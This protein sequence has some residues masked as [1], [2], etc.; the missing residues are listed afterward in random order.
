MAI[1]LKY[2]NIYYCNL[3]QTINSCTE[4]F[5]F[6]SIK[7]IQDYLMRCCL[8]IV[9]LAFNR[10]S[11]QSTGSPGWQRNFGARFEA[12]IPQSSLTLG[13]RPGCNTA[14]VKLTPNA[15]V[16]LEE[17]LRVNLLCCLDLRGYSQEPGLLR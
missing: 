9:P 1:P 11:V 3:I 10:Q 8:L 15:P 7:V 16:T 6:F 13:H 12:P 14:P 4:D 5:T 17:S 2:A